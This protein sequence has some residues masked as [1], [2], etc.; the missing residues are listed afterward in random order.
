[1]AAAARA[2]RGRGTP[3]YLFEPDVALE[4]LRRWR[5]AAGADMDLFYPWKCNRHDAL[6]DLAESEGLGAEATAAEDLDAILGRFAG[7]R[8]LFQGPA[9]RPDAIARAIAAGVWLIADSEED[10]EAIL[11]VGRSLGIPPRYLLRFRPPGV[12]TSQHAFG[13]AP[14]RALEVCARL[15]RARRPLPAGLS[16]H[17]GTGIPSPAPF[18]EAIREA[19]G[20]ARSLRSR[21]IPSSVLNVG[22]GFAALREARRSLSGG[23]EGRPASA[24]EYLG[25]IRKAVREF[26]PAPGLRVFAEPGRAIAS[27]AFH[28]V[29]RVVRVVGRRVYVDASRMS[30]AY[31]VPRGRHPFIPVPRRPG[32]G[33]S[34]VAGPLPVDLDRLSNGETIGRPRDG[35]LL[36][37]GA[38]GAYNLI[39]ANAW[40]GR[41]PDVVEVS[42]SR[43]AR[44]SGGP[45]RR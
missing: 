16:F 44:R 34:E 7:S 19:G 38:V 5:K 11:A 32:A 35:D 18:V 12:Q 4:R 41:M 10:A 24:D 6:V 42:A 22:G 15:R 17:L 8:V 1:V 27:D 36:L 2:A 9:K 21:G 13:L 29:T 45:T 43:G 14:E 40:A 39:V 20:L 23:P 25:A 30:H 31:F 33:K 3:F 26:L 28:L 37:I